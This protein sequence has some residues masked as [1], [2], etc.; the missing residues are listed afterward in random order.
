MIGNSQ[1]DFDNVTIHKYNCG[2]E[3]EL[4]DALRARATAPEMMRQ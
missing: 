2:S 1:D 3:Q 4:R